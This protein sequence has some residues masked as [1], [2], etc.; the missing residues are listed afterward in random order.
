M[1]STKPA[2][3]DPAPR[4]K[5]RSF[6]PE[7]KLRIVAECDGAP[8]NE[9]GAVLRRERLYHSHVKE[10]RAARDAGALENLVDRRTGPARVKK[11]ATEVENEKLRQQVE[12]LQK[13]LARNK[14][15]LEVMGKASALL[16][17]ISESAD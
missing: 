3:S 1:T 14:A 4:P 16:E 7:Y 13:D 6:S 17:M 5:R 10:W 12:R 15:A 8:R 11:S 9:K 2:G